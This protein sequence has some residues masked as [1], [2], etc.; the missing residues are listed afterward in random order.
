[1]TTCD[2]LLWDVHIL[3]LGI[4][5]IYANTINAKMNLQHFS[6]R[7]VMWYKSE[8]Y[9]NS[10]FTSSNYEFY[11]GVNAVQV[12]ISQLRNCS[13]SDNSNMEWT[14]LIYTGNNRGNRENLWMIKELINKD[15][16]TMVQ[17]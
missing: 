4:M 6:G 10:E 1:M 13:N 2:F 9:E 12:E 3:R 16:A 5:H 14:Y 17:N 7:A 15:T 8:L 11:K